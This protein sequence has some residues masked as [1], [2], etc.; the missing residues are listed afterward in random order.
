MSTSVL[1]LCLVVLGAVAFVAARGRATALAG[2]KS[3]ALHSRPGYYGA[4]AAIWA[5]LPAL[6]VLCAWLIISPSIIESSVRGGF[7]ESPTE[8]ELSEISQL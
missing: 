3:S 6:L 8:K 1:L 4:Y 2:G 7:P 5:V